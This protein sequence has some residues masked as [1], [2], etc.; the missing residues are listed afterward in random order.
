MEMF[1]YIFSS[2]SPS[3]LSISSSDFIKLEARCFL[4]YVSKSLDGEP[5]NSPG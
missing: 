5:S 1:I 3:F 2:L 4:D